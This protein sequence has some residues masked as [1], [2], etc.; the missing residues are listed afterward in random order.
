[1]QIKFILPTVIRALTLVVIVGA[2]LLIN[3]ELNNQNIIEYNQKAAGL[4]TIAAK[5]AITTK[6]PP[7]AQTKVQPV[8]EASPEKKAAKVAK[9]AEKPDTQTTRTVANNTT[10][11]ADKS[12]TNVNTNSSTNSSS[13]AANTTSYNRINTNQT[14]VLKSCA[15]LNQRPSDEARLCCSNYQLRSGLCVSPD[16]NSNDGIT[17]RIS[18]NNQASV[19]CGTSGQT[20]GNGGTCCITLEKSG[21]VCI[22]AGTVN[23]LPKGAACT[24][25][26]QSSCQSGFCCT[27]FNLCSDSNTGPSRCDFLTTTVTA[28]TGPKGAACSRV[29]SI[30]TCTSGFCCIDQMRC[31]GSS[32]SCDLPPVNDPEALTLIPNNAC[33]LND[34]VSSNTQNCSCVPNPANSLQTQWSCILTNPIV[35]PTEFLS[36][37]Q[38]ELLSP[39]D[40]TS[41]TEAP[42]TLNVSNP[43]GSSALNSDSINISDNSNSEVNQLMSEICSN[44]NLDNGGDA[45]AFVNTLA[46]NTT[47][48]ISES[49]LCSAQ[50]QI[51][52][53]QDLEELKVLIGLD[54]II[55]TKVSNNIISTTLPG[56]DQRQARY[57]INE[58]LCYRDLAEKCDSNDIRAKANK[59]YLYSVNL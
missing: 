47:L 12:G 39:L 51:S 34:I 31:S 55:F 38:R 41:S 4:V 35:V 46:R 56:S 43:I 45:N 2:G 36:S 5:A 48:I 11:P 54:S 52:S 49:N 21:D 16:N 1:M 27:G 42:S 32:S 44:N 33:T 14:R 15:G 58:Y 8:K 57:T 26:G 53:N 10:K 18:N 7:E 22:T 28:G 3:T 29:D 13:A 25:N 9:P 30:I 6:K 37:P 50:T 17:Q 59:V 24:T 20:V 23:D 40:S 19:Q